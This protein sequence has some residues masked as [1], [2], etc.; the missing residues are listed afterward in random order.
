RRVLFRSI[1]IAITFYI[2]IGYFYEPDPLS[3]MEWLE[4]FVIYYGASSI[5]GGLGGGIG[6]L[7]KR[8]PYVLLTLLA[9]LILQLLEDGT[10]SW[11]DIVGVGENFTYCLLIISIIIYLI[12]LRRNKKITAFDIQ[13]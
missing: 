3:F 7:L 9:G 5:G 8:A 11:C 13:R 2:V 4:S 12:T 10:S 1:I 6:F